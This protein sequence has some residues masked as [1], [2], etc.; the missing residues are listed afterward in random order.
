MKFPTQE[1]VSNRR[2]AEQSLAHSW[3]D[4]KGVNV[5]INARIERLMFNYEFEEFLKKRIFKKIG[6]IADK[7]QLHNSM[8]GEKVIFKKQEVENINGK[9]YLLTQQEK[10]TI[11]VESKYCK[12][13][14][15]V[16]FGNYRQQYC[17]ICKKC[18]R[19]EST[20]NAVAKYEVK[21]KQSA[22]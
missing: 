14:G 5:N 4:K 16:I 21:T 11:K 17:K 3:A 9:E 6:V 7:L 12:R 8:N 2:N 10:K 1:A 20:R 22:L 18:L 15:R 13:C 19:R